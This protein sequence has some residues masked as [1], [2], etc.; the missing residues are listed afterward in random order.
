MA[1]GSAL[2]WVAVSPSPTVFLA[3]MPWFGFAVVSYS[4]SMQAFVQHRSPRE[5]TG[6]VMSL[7]T[8]GTLGT[9]PLGGLLVGF[10]VD[11]VS[12]RAAVGLGGASALMAG[13]A[14]LRLLWRR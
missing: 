9:T 2:L 14:L 3:S 10:I 11:H 7:Y 4:V 13:V 12:P 1:L 8:L 6:R 5:M